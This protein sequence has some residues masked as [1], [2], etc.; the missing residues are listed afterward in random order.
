MYNL[1]TDRKSKHGISLITFMLKS[2]YC[3]PQPISPRI[4]RYLAV[5]SWPY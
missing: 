4:S 1:L 5:F 3:T 2:S